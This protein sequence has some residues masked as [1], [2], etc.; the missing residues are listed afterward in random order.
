MNISAKHYRT[1]WISEDSD[2]V[3]QIIDQRSVPH[4]FIVQD[5]T[6]VTDM[7]IAINDA[8]PVRAAAD[9]GMYLASLESPQDSKGNF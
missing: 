5:I 4:E 1:I 7:V 3:I 9:F 6:S 2:A 8:G